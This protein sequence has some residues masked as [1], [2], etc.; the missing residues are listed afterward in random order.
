V[1]ALVTH[2]NGRIALDVF[3]S[4]FIDHDLDSRFE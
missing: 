3:L 1:R 4:M 2:T